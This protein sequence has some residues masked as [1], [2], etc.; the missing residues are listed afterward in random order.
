ME[1]LNQN[2]IYQA[3]DKD[4]D[5]DIVR[6]HLIP[7][8]D[9]QEFESFKAYLDDA[10]NGY[11]MADNVD[12]PKIEDIIFKPPNKPIKDIDNPIKKV[13][14][15]EQEVDKNFNVVQKY[16][17]EKGLKFYC[18]EKKAN[19][20]I[21]GFEPFDY[22]NEDELDVLVEYNGSE[23]GISHIDSLIPA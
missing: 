22:D 3:K 16:T 5:C 10:L 8:W 9:K 1:R 18:S 15:T 19:C 14:V 12:T 2:I 21:T 20:I 7:Q 17:I 6:E 13:L 4:L 11:N 23:K